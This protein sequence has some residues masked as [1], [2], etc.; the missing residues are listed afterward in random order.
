MDPSNYIVAGILADPYTCLDQ[1]TPYDNLLSHFCYL[2]GAPEEK[3]VQSSP[4]KSDW[5]SK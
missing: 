4:G 3:H 1:I 2:W 5:D